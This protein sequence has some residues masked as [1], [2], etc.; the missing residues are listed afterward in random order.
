MIAKKQKYP[1]P[2]KDQKNQ[3]PAYALKSD[4]SKTKPNPNPKEDQTKSESCLCCQHSDD[5]KTKPLKP[6]YFIFHK[7]QPW[8]NKVQS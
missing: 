3:H 8:Q 5:G 6:D 7:G 1:D 4:N 2:K